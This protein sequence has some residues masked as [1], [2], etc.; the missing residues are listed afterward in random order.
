MTDV[1]KYHITYEEYTTYEKGGC[2]DS[3]KTTT[4]IV[5]FTDGTIVH[6]KNGQ[7]HNENGPSIKS[8]VQIQYC[9][10]GM[11]HNLNG[12]GI[13]YSFQGY[14]N[15]LWYIKSIRIGEWS[16][17]LNNRIQFGLFESTEYDKPAKEWWFGNE[18][19]FLILDFIRDE[20]E[21]KI[22]YVKGLT[23]NGIR[24]V[25]ILPSMLKFFGE[26][27]SSLSNELSAIYEIKI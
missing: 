10:D 12:P 15:Y 17:S 4:G 1:I 8:A 21:P 13:I 25:Y 18:Q 3:F 14:S 20:R 2:R 5:E 27:L 9:I 11:L 23:P 24:F 19:K 16:N 6:L 7:P 22:I 26:K